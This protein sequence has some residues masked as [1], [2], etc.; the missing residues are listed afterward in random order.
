MYK[1]HEKEGV[2]TSG[3]FPQ[4]VSSLCR[5]FCNSFAVDRVR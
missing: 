3:F 1:K 4:V 2:A 5:L